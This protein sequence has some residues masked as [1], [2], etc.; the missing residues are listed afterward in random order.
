MESGMI[1]TLNFNIN[2]TMSDTP[3]TDEAWRL[4]MEGDCP[5]HKMSLLAN[6]LE[7]ELIELKR[8]IGHAMKKEY[9]LSELF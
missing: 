8:S 2:R 1:G 3:R 4:A 6:E 9:K 7:R 5:A